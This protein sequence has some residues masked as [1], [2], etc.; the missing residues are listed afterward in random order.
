MKIID[1]NGRERECD[2]IRLVERETQK[3]VRVSIISK[4]TGDI[5]F[6]W[7]PVD[8]FKNRNPDKISML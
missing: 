3:W 5:H 7:Y 2:D 8:D 1:V 4:K 6:E